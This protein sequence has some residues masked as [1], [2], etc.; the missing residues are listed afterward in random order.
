MATVQERVGIV[1][2]KLESVSEK[3]ID[4]KADVKEMHDC[5]D[6]TRDVVLSQLDKMTDEYRLNASKYYDHANNLNKLQSD[7]HK[8]LAG[9]IDNLEKFKTKGT[10]YVMLVLAFAAGTG[11]MGH[12]DLAKLIKFIGI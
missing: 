10:L 9:K 4:L 11:W 12:L 1:E 5:L 2:T 7:Q 3:I 6:N 8:E